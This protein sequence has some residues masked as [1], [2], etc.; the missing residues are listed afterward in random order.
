MEQYLSLSENPQPADAGVQPEVCF[1]KP[2]N[3]TSVEP[4]RV[5]DLSKNSTRPTS[6]YAWCR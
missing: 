4:R 2:K 3:R 1:E 6:V 5:R